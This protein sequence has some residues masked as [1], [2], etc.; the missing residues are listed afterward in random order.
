MLYAISSTGGLKT[1]NRRPSG[2]TDEEW[3]LNL[4]DQLDVEL[5]HQC[6]LMQINLLKK[7][8]GYYDLEDLKRFQKFAEE[9]ADSLRISYGLE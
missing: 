2:T 3:Y 7:A 9:T 6:R 5:S 8:D 1:W 4:W